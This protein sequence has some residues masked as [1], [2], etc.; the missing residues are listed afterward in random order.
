MNKDID[1]LLLAL[2]N[3]H[4]EKG[5]DKFISIGSLTDLPKMQWQQIAN[6]AYDWGLIEYPV[7][8]SSYTAAR[9]SKTGI[10]RLKQIEKKEVAETLERE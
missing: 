10:E 9:I 4:K 6:K 1:D 5:F 7:E 8:E 3:T 2:Y